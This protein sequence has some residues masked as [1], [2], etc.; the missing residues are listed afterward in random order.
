MINDVVVSRLLLVVVIMHV[1]AWLEVWF[2]WYSCS[3]FVAVA[4]AVDVGMV[5]MFVVDDDSCYYFED[6]WIDVLDYRVIMPIWKSLHD[7][8]D[9]VYCHSLNDAIIFKGELLVGLL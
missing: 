8:S 3:Y 6:D 4:V 2:L 1:E 7:H 5:V 9:V